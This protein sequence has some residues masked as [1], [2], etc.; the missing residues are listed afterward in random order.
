M[1]QRL[2]NQVQ[3]SKQAQVRIEQFPGLGVY[4]VLLLVHKA[5]DRV[6]LGKAYLRVRRIGSYAQFDAVPDQ[7]QQQQAID[8]C[9]RISNLG[10]QHRREITLACANSAIWRAQPTNPVVDDRNARHIDGFPDQ[11]EQVELNVTP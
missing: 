7:T 2:G 5:L 11:V 10:P 8:P 3:L 1:V 6:G 4:R 9:A